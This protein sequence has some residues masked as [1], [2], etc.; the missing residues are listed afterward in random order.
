MVLSFLVLFL[1]SERGFSPESAGFVMF[2]YGLGAICAAAARGQAG[3]PP[4]VRFPDAD[5]ALRVGSGPS[6]STRS[7]A[8]T[9][10]SSRRPS[11]LAMLTESF[12]PAAMSFFGEAVPAAQR[13]SAFAV[14]RLAIN[15]GMAIGPA[16]GGFLATISFRWLF[17]ADGATSLAAGVVLAMSGLVLPGPRRIVPSNA[18][19]ATRIRL[20]TAAHADPASSSSW[21]ACCP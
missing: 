4:R 17:V 1:T 16:V 8:R 6:C 18:T 12:R 3:R 13:K 19:T 21:R 10:R 15:L 20:S 7:R 5:L 14:Y 11:S 9:R 2:L